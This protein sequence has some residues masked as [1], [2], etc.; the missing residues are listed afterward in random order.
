MVFKY[1]KPKALSNLIKTK[2]SIKLVILE[3][4]Y[5]NRMLSKKESVNEL[6]ERVHNLMIEDLE[7]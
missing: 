5:P 6:K 4:V 3:P 2:P 1:T 7:R